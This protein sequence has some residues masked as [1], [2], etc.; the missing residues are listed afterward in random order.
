[1]SG[2]SPSASPS[3]SPGS[4]QV[5]IHEAAE[6]A[7]RLAHALR[8][9]DAPGG[10]AHSA[11]SE[12]GAEELLEDLERLF[13]RHRRHLSRDAAGVCENWVSRKLSD[14]GLAP[15]S[16]EAA[17]LRDFAEA[18]QNLVRKRQEQGPSWRMS[19]LGG[20]PFAELRQQIR[21]WQTH[22]FSEVGP[23]QRQDSDETAGQQDL[24]Q[25][26]GAP[27][28]SPDTGCL[29]TAVCVDLLA[30][31]EELVSSRNSIGA[32]F[33]HDIARVCQQWKSRHIQAESLPDGA[34]CALL[35]RSLSDLLRT[36]LSSDRGQQQ[37]GRRACSNLLNALKKLFSQGLERPGTGLASEISKVCKSWQIREGISADSES[38]LLVR[39]IADTLQ[40]EARHEASNA[41]VA[42]SCGTEEVGQKSVAPGQHCV[43]TATQACVQHA[44][45]LDCATLLHC[46][47]SRLS[48]CVRCW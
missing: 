22:F 28:R 25:L 41:L 38:A 30:A 12:L 40:A 36:S 9:A 18:M 19:N 35:L 23:E 7:E 3:P 13:G 47:L 20:N 8:Q 11:Y 27:S 14:R 42:M 39:C 48:F 24:Q 4:L 34:G 21:A 6:L 37:G 5:I 16:P 10:L 43:A 2:V 46:A 29:Q 45:V 1:M 26:S 31:L 32:E 17:L 33:K 44:R 15:T